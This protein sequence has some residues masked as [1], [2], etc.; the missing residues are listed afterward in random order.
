MSEHPLLVFPTPEIA[1]LSLRKRGFGKIEKPSI[2]R[3]GERLNPIFAQLQSA[4]DERRFELLQNTAGIDPEQVL[5]IETIGGIKDFA[6]AI[7]RVEGLEW[8]GE[9]EIED[10]SPDQDF[11]DAKDNQKT[12]RG[13]LYII[14]TNQRALNEMFSLWQR[15]EDNPD[16]EFQRGLT[17]FRDVFL[18]LKNIR[19]WDV[20]DRL[21][22]T[23]VIEIWHEELEADGNKIVSF[24][25]ELW[26]RRNLQLRQIS[27][28]Q[29]TDLV[30]KL[31]GS[32]R[33]QCIIEGISY[34]G[35]LVE[36]PANAIHSI[37][38]NNTIELVRCDNIMF[39]RP[40]GQMITGDEVVEGSIEI[41]R[42]EEREL[43]KEPPII[44]LLDGYPLVNHSWLRG[45]V[46]IDDPDNWEE[47]YSSSDRVHG[48]AMASL[49]IHGD[50]LDGELPLNSLIYV[51]PIMKPIPWFRT[52]KPE[53][54]PDNCLAVDLIHKAVKRI[55]EGDEGETPIAPQIKIINLSIGDRSRQFTQSMSPLA[56]LIDWLS[57]KYRVL[58]IVSAGN[59]STSI[60]LQIS[61]EDFNKLD[62]NSKEAESV[63][64]LYRDIRNRKL[65]SPAES[66]NAITVGAVHFDSSPLVVTANVVN[67]FENILPSPLSAFGSGYRRA[68]KPDII[69]KGGRQLY[70]TP[71]SNT[72][73]LSL[74]PIISY[75]SPGNKVA[76]PGGMAGNLGSEKF[77]CGTSNATALISRAAAICFES[78]QQ[79]FNAHNIELNTN[80]CG[81]TLLKA[82]LIHGCSWGEISSRISEVLETRGN[83]HQI[84]ELISKWTGYGIP[85]IE[86]VLDC[87]DQR[88]TL[89][90]YGQLNNEEAHVFKLPLPPS[91]GSN[92]E[93]RRLTITLAWLSPISA[94]TQKYRTASL[95]F[96]TNNNNLAQTRSDADW[97]AVRR[98]TI[99]HEVFEDQR[100]IPFV[101]GDTIEIKVNCREDAGEI[102]NPISYGLMVS[103]EVKENVD[104]SIYNEIR[105]RIATAIQINQ[106]I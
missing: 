20:Q 102:L 79:I 8:L 25:I 37:L 86:R 3:Q 46:Q 7:S 85:N 31:G 50:I 73:T 43:P 27:V 15:F 89:L 38:E 22:E 61:L 96:D 67:P 56:R 4:F 54:I 75:G 40:V 2:K 68:I 10:I 39:F 35:L 66:I 5:V 83:S 103:L 91:L 45:R 49:I 70:R 29:V 17:K 80:P 19:R 57:E 60:N 62:A 28:A 92:K 104:I 21:L 52:P 77:S 90:G 24:E 71:Y 55:F 94:N 47:D 98:G 100:A 32:I 14:M 41:G 53:C 72:E 26:F 30:Q 105:T 81:I 74:S 69:Y 48:T 13:R 99:Q 11:F 51:R 42:F 34:H 9:L 82:M 63:K 59:H 23:G 97:N 78:L 6:N 87:T 18:Q 88:V 76:S 106:Q 64:A 65:L 16:M 84:R 12:L 1:S 101:D 33:D 95:W 36:L 44:A 58:F 93:W